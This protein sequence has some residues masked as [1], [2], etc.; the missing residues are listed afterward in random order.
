MKRHGGVTSPEGADRVESSAQARGTRVARVGHR[1][2][3]ALL[4]EAERAGLFLISLDEVR[5]WWRYHHLFADPLR[6]RLLQLEPG[7]VHLAT[8]TTTGTPGQRPTGRNSRHYGQA[9]VLEQGHQFLVEFR[10]DRGDRWYAETAGLIAGQVEG[11]MGCGE[12]DGIIAACPDAMGGDH[13]AS[14][15]AVP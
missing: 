15:C 1:L 14:C 6:A 8:G 3:A 4:E 11:E 10:A 13:L 5:G 9:E 7:R 12:E 2:F